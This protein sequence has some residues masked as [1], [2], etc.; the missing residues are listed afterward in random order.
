MNSGKNTNQ[1]QGV[2]KSH[3]MRTPEYYESQV[4]AK[5]FADKQKRQRESPKDDGQASANAQLVVKQ[6][7][8][9]KSLRSQVKKAQ[10]KEKSWGRKL[11][12]AAIIGGVV[13]GAVFLSKLLFLALASSAKSFKELRSTVSGNPK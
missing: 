4:D 5:I 10:A 9:L 8:E 11:G 12:N 7:K 2:P 1:K 13:F 6:H 3:Q